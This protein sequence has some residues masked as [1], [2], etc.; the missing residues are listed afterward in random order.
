MSITVPEH[1]AKSL[2]ADAIATPRGSVVDDAA[3]AADAARA[4]GCA[5]ALK[6]QIPAGKRGKAGGIAFAATPDEAAV[7][8]QALLG[9]SIAGHRV[10]RLLVEPQ[11]AIAREFYAAVLADA[12]AKV[13]VL[14]FSTEGGVDI[15]DVHA[16]S[17]EKILRLA[18]DPRRMLGAAQIRA[19]LEPAALDA[20]L[21]EH[22]VGVL[23]SL[24]C[25]YADL[26]AE[27]LEINPLA[28]DPNGKLWA[29][30]CKMG[31][32][33]SARAQRKDLFAQVERALGPQG[34]ALERRAREA[35]LYFIELD[36][37]V[38]VLA[39]GA[40]LT[41]TTIDA[42]A[43]FGGEPANFMEIGGDAYTKALPALEIVLANP[44]VKSLL[45]NFCGAF[46]RT[47]VMTEG[48]IAAV[49]TLHPVVPM[50]FSIHGT[51]EDIAI[52]L[53]RERL[54]IEPYD[55]MDDA[56]KAAVAA[57]RSAGEVPV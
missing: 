14:L 41:M 33:E 5:V 30:D 38:G 15:E 35:G 11:V 48:V 49:E 53:L 20:A 25:K 1:L 36:G 2:I 47:D 50:F 4:L 9:S 22:V 13:P 28:V 16:A 12:Q 56:V 37:D 17:P 26:G 24:V 19:L 39:N 55:D 54:G 8:A 45:I 3:Q 32:D 10:E 51:G 7:K 31:L 27:L 18:L 42:V 6:A 34:T 29:L 43:H 52:P 40:G 21:L 46:A 57:A 44:K 23:D